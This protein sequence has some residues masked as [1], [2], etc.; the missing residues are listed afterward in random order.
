M[1]HTGPPRRRSHSGTIVLG[2]IALDLFVF[3]SVRT[4]GLVNWDDPTYLIDNPNV[5]HGLTWASVRWALVTGHAPYWHPVTWLSHLADITLFGA[6][7]GW[8][9]VVNLGFHVANTLLVF[10][11]FRRT[12]RD[13]WPSAFV[14]AIFGVH[15]LHV[16]SVAWIAERKD[17]LSTFFWALTVLAYVRYTNKTTSARY[18]VVCAMFALA[19]ASKPMVVTLP[20]VLLLFDVWPLHRDNRMRWT[21]LVIE[22]VPLVLL[23]GAAT[24]VTIRVQQHVGALASVGSL[25]WATRAEHAIVSYVGYLWKVVW[26]AKLS[27]FYPYRAPAPRMALISVAFLAAVT[28]F[29]L[30]ERARRPW[31][32][33]GWL[34]FLITLAPVIGIVQSGE[35]AMADRFMYVPLIGLTIM[36]AWGARDLSASTHRSGAIALG[37]AVLVIASTLAAR[38]QV[39]HWEDSIALWTHAMAVTPDNYIAYENM[40]QARRE[41][42][43]F[44]QAIESYRK[45]LAAAPAHSPKYEA[46]IHNAIGLVLEREGRAGASMEEFQ[47]AVA[48][49]PEFPEAQANLAN[50]LAERGRFND[51]VPYYEAAIKLDPASTEAQLG[52]GNVLLSA[53][54]AAE[55]IPH[56]RAALKLQPDLAQAHNG[57]GAALA[58]E[59]RNAEAHDELTAALTLD[60]SLTTAHYNLAVLL[61]K[62]GRVDEARAELARALETNPQYEPARALLHVLVPPRN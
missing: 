13:E 49:N 43:E 58:H 42:G 12:T 48:S 44:D 10:Q 20:A 4:F 6:D 7:A 56:Y 1:N 26:P 14:A 25:P 9:H 33:V 11:I 17:V 36:A 62:E 53:G 38:G 54:D 39:A 22:K 60:P 21:R 50:A 8:Y 55:A 52:L 19:L 34:W 51:A 28:V 18:A 32:T 46:V 57:L 41:R 30:R 29:V 27:A 35:Q 16:E 31:L 2:L 45:A 15:P 37:G 40:G 59:D 3:W 61:V 5:A 47:R 23:A 24:V